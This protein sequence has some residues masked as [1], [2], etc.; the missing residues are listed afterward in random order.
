MAHGNLC[1]FDPKKESIEDF[2][3][4]YCVA[5]NVRGDDADKKKAMFLTLLGQ[6]TF[7]KLKVLASPTP[8]IEL[9]FGRYYGTP[10]STF[11]SRHH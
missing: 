4:Y 6:E 9:M 11:S 7:A 5:N 3:E 1:E 2:L 10:D 8:V